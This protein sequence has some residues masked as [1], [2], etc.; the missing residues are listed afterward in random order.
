MTGACLVA[1]KAVVHEDD[2]GLTATLD[3]IDRHRADGRIGTGFPLPCIGETPRWIDFTIR[4]DDAM[5]LADGATIWMR[6][7]PPTRTSISAS[8]TV[9]GWC[10]AFGLRGFEVGGQLIELRFPESSIPLDPFECPAHRGRVYRC[11]T[12][13]ESESCAGPRAMIAYSAIAGMSAGAH[14]AGGTIEI[15]SEPGRGTTVRASLPTGS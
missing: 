12:P 15:A 10:S 6:Y 11:A 2:F 3:E 5:L 1:R 7:S 8:A 9:I 4:S 13:L 14:R